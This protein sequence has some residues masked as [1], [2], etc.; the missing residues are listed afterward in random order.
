MYRKVEDFLKS[1]KVESE[2]TQKLLD[3]LTDASLAQAVADEHRTIGRLVWH[4]ITSLPEMARRTG[5]KLD[6]AP[7]P[8]SKPPMTVAAMQKAYKTTAAALAERV[9]ADW[10]DATLEIE[11]DMYGEQWKRGTTLMILQ[12]HEVHHRGQLTVLMRQAGLTVPGIYGPA[13]EE[14]SQ[15]NMPAPEV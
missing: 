15:Y 6:G 5:L 8:D 12:T 11:D 13:K 9:K 7:E 10:D 3:T 14:W 1:W 4:I 2:G